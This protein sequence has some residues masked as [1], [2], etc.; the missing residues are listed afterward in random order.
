MDRATAERLSELTREFYAQVAES[1]SATRQSAWAGW[2]RVLGLCGRD[3][4][5][6]LRV[7]DVACGNLRF[8]RFLAEA[9]VGAQVRAVDACD[10][11][12][13]GS[14]QIDDINNVSISYSCL[15][16]AEALSEEGALSAALGKTGFDLAVCFG[17]MHHLPLREQRER[18]LKELVACL[19]PGGFVAVSFWQL[20]KSER[21]LAKARACTAR[22][23]AE[24]GIQGLDA[25]DYLLGWQD[26]DEVF[27]YCHDFSEE[28]IDRLADSVSP[29]ARERA[30]FS[31]DG[32][33]GNLNRY[34]I[35]EA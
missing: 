29:I 13:L 21:L 25:G 3:G 7:A 23:T 1:F 30:R 19:L 20:S 31:A 28:E 9:Q 27:R 5:A 6:E 11:L 4:A 32:A 16:V 2:E 14:G 34:L 17:F 26:R 15:D 10:S 12:S 35:L 33:T 8:E 18:L 22:A 24:L